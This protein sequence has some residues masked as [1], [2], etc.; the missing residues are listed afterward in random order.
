MEEIILSF[1]DANAAILAEQWLMRCGFAPRVMPLPSSIRA[2]CGLCLRVRPDQR[3][4]AV[5]LLSA[6][7]VRVSGQ[8]LRRVEQSGSTYEEV[9]L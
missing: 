1:S 6:R 7:G 2:G 9:G 4:D 3:T 8:H 5:L